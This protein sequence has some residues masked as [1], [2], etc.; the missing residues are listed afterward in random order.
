[1][2]SQQLDDLE[3]RIRA[4]EKAIARL[5]NPGTLRSSEAV[6]LRDYFDAKLEASDRALSLAK[7]GMDHR[8]D[9]MNGIREDLRHQAAMFVTKNEISALLAPITAQLDVLQTF[10][11]QLQGKASAGQAYLALVLSLIGMV[12]GAIGLFVR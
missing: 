3:D 7:N 4:L 9:G 8:L 5:G 10:K 12:M 1:M 11:D 6:T 2:D